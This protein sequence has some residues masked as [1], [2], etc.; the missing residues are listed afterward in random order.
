[1]LMRSIILDLCVFPARTLQLSPYLTLGCHPKVDG[2]LSIFCGGSSSS[3]V[4]YR[5]IAN[6]PCGNSCSFSVM[7]WSCSVQLHR[8]YL[9][10]LLPSSFLLLLVTRVARTTKGMSLIVLGWAPSLWCRSSLILRRHNKWPLWHLS[11]CKSERVEV[12]V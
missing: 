4:N 9:L 3:R 10:F 11:G 8:P 6:I 1:M 2:F 5:H 12:P 7:P